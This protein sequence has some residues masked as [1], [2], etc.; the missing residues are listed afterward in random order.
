VPAASAY[1]V[2]WTDFVKQLNTAGGGALDITL[3]AG[4]AVAPATKEFDGVDQGILEM[5]TTCTMYWLDRWVASGLFTYTVGGLSP[6]EAMMWGMNEGIPLLNEMMKATNV[7]VIGGI[8][9]VPEAFMSS[10]KAINTKADIRGMKIRA[11]G[12]GGIMFSK[13]GASVVMLPGG[14]IYEALQRGVIDATEISSPGFDYTLATYEVI[15]YMYLSP[16]R[17]PC[18]WLPV[19]VNKKWWATVPDSLK[20]LLIEMTKGG[21]WNYLNKMSKADVVAIPTYKA[22]GVQVIPIPKDVENEMA[23]LAAAYYAEQAGKDAL[24]KRVYDSITKAQ[25]IYRETYSRL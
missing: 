15:K 18:E 17:Q 11:A 10:K 5:G 23:T 21:S 8:I 13:M 9:T 4:G 22:K 6:S 14:E 7:E 24:F 12:D 19:I 2:F 16:V 20:M 25:S 3:Y 1:T